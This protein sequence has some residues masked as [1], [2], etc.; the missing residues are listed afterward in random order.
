MSSYSQVAVLGYGTMGAGIAQVVAQSGRNVMV[1]ET[2]QAR[3]ASRLRSQ[4]L[5]SGQFS[6]TN[7]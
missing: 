6:I 3:I 2:D 7:L 4:A 5:A 1:L